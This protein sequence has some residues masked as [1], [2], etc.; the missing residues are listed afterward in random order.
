V[1]K[2]TMT[3]ANM[4]SMGDRGGNSRNGVKDSGDWCKRKPQRIHVFDRES[5]RL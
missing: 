2:G 3:G 4:G 1:H 5:R